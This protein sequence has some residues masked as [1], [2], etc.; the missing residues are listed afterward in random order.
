MPPTTVETLERALGYR[1]RERKLCELALTH[2]SATSHEQQAVD[3]ERMEFLGDS[4]LGVV[5]AQWLYRQH[6][7]WSE[8]ELTKGRSQLVSEAGLVRVG[9]AMQLGPLIRVGRSQGL[10]PIPSSV[11]AWA[12]EAVLGAVL[13]DGGYQAAERVIRRLWHPFMQQGRESVDHKSE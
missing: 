6:P 1:F 2:R 5:I 8:G 13:L 7:R 10:D 12:A 4:I 11:L 9:A 3:N